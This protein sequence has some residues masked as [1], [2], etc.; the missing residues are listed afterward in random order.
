MHSKLGILLQNILTTRGMEQMW[1]YLYCNFALVCILY[2]FFEHFLEPR[3]RDTDFK[4]YTPKK[5]RFLTLGSK[6]LAQA[7]HWRYFSCV[8]QWKPRLDFRQNFNFLILLFW[9]AQR[10]SIQPQ[11]ILNKKKA[12]LF[13]IWIIL[14]N[15]K[16]QFKF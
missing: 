9:F 13:F 16:N 15:N 11:V 12:R 7:I 2:A 8:I 1:F 5:Y 6:A 4:R 14:I 3:Y 10:K